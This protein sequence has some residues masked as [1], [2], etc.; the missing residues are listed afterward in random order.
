[1]QRLAEW[2]EAKPDRPWI[3]IFNHTLR[4]ATLTQ[5]GSSICFVGFFVYL[6]LTSKHSGSLLADDVPRWASK[7]NLALFW[8]FSIF[9]FSALTKRRYCDRLKLNPTEGKPAVWLEIRNKWSTTK[10]DWGHLELQAGCLS[11]NGEHTQFLL[12][13]EDIHSTAKDEHGS[14]SLTIWIPGTGQRL[15]ILNNS[16]S[17]EAWEHLLDRLNH[18]EP[19]NL[20]STFPPKEKSTALKSLLYITGCMFLGEI[21]ILLT[22]SL[23]KNFSGYESLSLAILFPTTLGLLA[24]LA[25]LVNLRLWS[26]RRQ[27]KSQTAL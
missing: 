18:Q 13:L 8:C 24:W 6:G 27:L 20:L 2:H 16:E 26:K 7:A 19:S 15:K 12:N 4:N 1:M 21:V 14:S 10:M 23:A 5:W 17:D 3:A 9:G 22:W 25:L 11:F